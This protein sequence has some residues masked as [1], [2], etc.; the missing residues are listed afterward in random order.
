MKGL[1]FHWAHDK[2]DPRCSFYME[3]PRDKEA[4]WAAVSGGA[5]SWTRLKRLS[6]SSSSIHNEGQATD[7][8]GVQPGEQRWGPLWKV[9]DDQHISRN[10]NYLQNLCFQ[11][12]RSTSSPLLFSKVVDTDIVRGFF[13]LQSSPRHSS[14]TCPPS[15]KTVAPRE[16]CV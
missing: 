3:N 2:T 5:Q 16:E 4:W 6:S 10:S 11:D 14:K 12:S 1:V 13:L 9:T 8:T 15:F 7:H